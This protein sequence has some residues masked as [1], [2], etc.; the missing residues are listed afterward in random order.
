MDEKIIQ[1][2]SA[3]S[4]NSSGFFLL[5]SYGRIFKRTDSPEKWVELELPE[6]KKAERGEKLRPA[7]PSALR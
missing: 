7:I 1:I 2:S 4:D 6:L 5:T 3:L